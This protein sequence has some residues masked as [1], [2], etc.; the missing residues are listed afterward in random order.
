M[1]LF[2]KTFKITKWVVGLGGV[3]A[4]LYIYSKELKLQCAFSNYINKQKSTS[5]NDF[6]FKL[7]IDLQ[8]CSLIF[9]LKNLLI[10]AHGI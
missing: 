4:L 10:Q 7:A 2:E 9:L 1:K 8:N 5:G 6:R 3:I